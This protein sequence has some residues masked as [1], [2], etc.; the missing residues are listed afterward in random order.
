MRGGRGALL[1]EGLCIHR[2]CCAG[3]EGGGECECKVVESRDEVCSYEGDGGG[4]DSMALGGVKSQGS[5]DGGE[6]A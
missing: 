1:W 4:G 5:A 6:G 3:S 2:S